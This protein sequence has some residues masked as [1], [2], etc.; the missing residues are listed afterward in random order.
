[1]SVFGDPTKY[2]VDADG[3]QPFGVGV[4]EDEQT[5]SGDLEALLLQT[6]LVD[7]AH[8][9]KS[10]NLLPGDDISEDA[11][12]V[13]LGGIGGGRGKRRRPAIYNLGWSSSSPS[14]TD[15]VFGS[16]RRPARPLRRIWQARL[17]LGNPVLRTRSQISSIALSRS[18]R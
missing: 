12:A 7:W 3:Q 9:R 1:M 11:H 16:S 17:C 6:R 14:E 18:A 8:R 4:S 15:N 13:L 5:G 10:K 2:Y